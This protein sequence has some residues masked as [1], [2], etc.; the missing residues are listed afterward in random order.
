MTGFIFGLTLRQ[1][2][3]RRTTLLLVGLA[4][5]PVLLAVAFR[6]ASP[7]TEPDEWVARVLMAGLIAT[8]VLPLTA[9]L[10]GT[11]AL[12]DEIEDG[13]AVY[14][15]TKPIPRWQILLPKLAATT[16]LTAALT[17]VATA[18]SAA[19]ALEG[20]PAILVGFTIAAAAGAA[21]YCTVFVL[22]SLATS[23]ALIAGLVYIFLWEGAVTAIFTGTR[24]FSIRHYTLGF[25]DWLADTPPDVYDATVAGPLALALITLVIAAACLLANRRLQ[26]TEIREPS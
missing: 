21:A 24:Y 5:I 4:C 9:L 15:L 2:L 3:G 16:L 26:R 17:A 14:L 6:L 1:F 10:L 12:G 8:A 19:I 11:T 13:T 23:R 7:D 22:V 20:D 25:G 18:V